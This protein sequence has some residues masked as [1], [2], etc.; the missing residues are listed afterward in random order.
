MARSR[1]RGSLGAGVS[2]GPKSA[3]G[4]TSTARQPSTNGARPEVE[5]PQTIAGWISLLRPI[6]PEHTSLLTEL[7][8]EDEGETGWELLLEESHQLLNRQNRPATAALLSAAIHRTAG[9]GRGH[10][11]RAW[12]ATCAMAFRPPPVS[13]NIDQEWL[14]QTHRAAV[15]L[16]GAFLQIARA[17]PSIGEDLRLECLLGGLEILARTHDRRFGFGH[18]LPGLISKLESEYPRIATELSSFVDG[19]APAISA[20]TV[21]DETLRKWRQ[22]LDSL[23]SELNDGIGL[24]ATRGLAL[25]SRI[26]SDNNRRVFRPIVEALE[27]ADHIDAELAA[28]INGLSPQSLLD[29]HPL[30]QAAG[31]SRKI[32]GA[33]RLDTIRHYEELAHKAQEALKLRQELEGFRKTSS[34]TD[35]GL[36]LE[37]SNFIGFWAERSVDATDWL[38]VRLLSADVLLVRSRLPIPDVSVLTRPEGAQL[39]P[40]CLFG[41]TEPRTFIAAPRLVADLGGSPS[42]IAD[43]L[44]DVSS[45]SPTVTAECLREEAGRLAHEGRFVVGRLWAAVC[46]KQAAEGYQ[47]Q[48]LL[49]DELARARKATLAE[50]ELV[51]EAVSARR[52]PGD[53]SLQE[54]LSTVQVQAQEGFLREAR[55]SFDEFCSEQFL[56][57]TELLAAPRRP[58]PAAAGELQTRDRD[59]VSVAHSEPEVAAEPRGAVIRQPAQSAN[60]QDGLLSVAEPSK[61]TSLSRGDAAQGSPDRDAL[62]REYRKAEDA[63]SRNRLREAHAS[64]Q[65]ILRADPRHLRARSQLV[66]VLDKLGRRNEA[67]DLLEDGLEVASTHV[68]FL[69][70]LVPLL[71]REGRLEEAR[72]YAQRGLDVCRNPGEEIGFLNDLVH[73]ERLT[74]NNEKAAGSLRRLVRLAPHIEH[75]QKL[76]H[77]L[78]G[79]HGSV[80]E[81]VD[82]RPIEPLPWELPSER[83]E[84]SPFLAL[85]LERPHSL[86]A[87]DFLERAG[88][89]KAVNEALLLWDKAVLTPD[90][91]RPGADAEALRTGAKLLAEVH[92]RCPEFDYLGYIEARKKQGEKL[93]S[94]RTHE[95]A[96][97]RW[98]SYYAAR[99]GDDYFMKQHTEPARAYYL[100]HFRVFGR[101][102]TF[103]AYTADKYIRTSLPEAQDAIS[104]GKEYLKRYRARERVRHAPEAVVVMFA[105]ILDQHLLGP[106]PM[107]DPRLAQFVSDFLDVCLSNEAARTALLRL[108]GDPQHQISKILWKVHC[109]GLLAVE[110]STPRDW[111]ERAM[112][113]R[114]EHHRLNE[115]DLAFVLSDLLPNRQY[116]RAIELMV[117]VRTRGCSAADQR[118]LVRVEDLL[119]AG[120]RFQRAR[121]FD[122]KRYL[123][124]DLSLRAREIQD[125]VE[126]G[127]TTLGRVHLAPL[128]FR[129]ERDVDG[130]F[131]RFKDRSPPS[132]HVRSIKSVRTDATVRAD[133]LVENQGLSPAE[134]LCLLFRGDQAGEQIGGFELDRLL[135]GASNAAVHK[136]DLRLSTPQD[137]EAMDVLV[138]GSYTDAEGRRHELPA[139]SVRLSISRHQ[140]YLWIENPYVTGGIIMDRQMFKGRDRLVSDILQEVENRRS[141][142]SVVIYGQKRCGKS[143]ILHWIAEGASDWVVPVSLPVQD[144]FADEAVLPSFLFLVAETIV[145]EAHARRNL[146]LPRIDQDELFESRVPSRV[147]RKY[148]ERVTVELGPDRRLLLLFDEFTDLI[149][150]IDRGDIERGFMRYLKSLIE[151]GLFSS[152]ICGIDTMPKALKRFSND[153][154]IADSRMISYLDDVSARELIEDPIRLSDGSSRFSAG[155][156]ERILQLTAGAPYY[157]QLLCSRLVD[158]LNREQNPDPHVTRADVD[159]TVR[160]M[161]V[162]RSKL[163]PWTVFDSLCRYKEDAQRDPYPAVLEGL[164]LYATADGMRSA[165]FVGHDSLVD[166]MRQRAPDDQIEFVLNDLLDRETLEIPKGSPVRQYRIRVGLFAE[167]ITANRPLDP[168]ALSGFAR[169]LE[170][171]AEQAESKNA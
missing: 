63:R 125:G 160:D 145:D 104:V 11:L 40:A 84:I 52:E 94:A 149:A 15:A 95:G 58:P 144:M 4:C 16:H 68:P 130:A 115:H 55:Q 110:A 43:L 35:E 45:Q 37:L 19:T 96:L 113:L 9:V 142:G 100:E 78:S 108:T 162:G 65:R 116:D 101:L 6:D 99:K 106:R 61:T 171:A 24:R 39:G 27:S 53:S 23:C 112:T 114:Q 64:F 90:T 60:H 22:R 56:D 138:S 75:Y 155:A 73:I 147:F 121:T 163:S 33:A 86:V 70:Q 14:R 151:H 48:V 38:L 157:V 117:Q 30:Q 127:P 156:I 1:A 109:R 124:S 111:V 51:R 134:N 170:T 146:E 161:I 97:R 105:A 17:T 12:E 83:L 54:R 136:A 102:F 128:V 89:E 79:P 8:T 44:R 87:G 91:A 80:P 159:E 164:A 165:E 148:L 103:S 77:Q 46:E 85:D 126:K 135:P 18:V 21:D 82:R 154:A 7:A 41:V 152:V 141:P 62:D 88:P 76:L 71:A 133:I 28:T 2:V 166:R 119:R 25:L 168:Q 81:S 123:S 42:S 122:D 98:I 32:S 131:Q 167:W 74:G 20:R 66:L 3:S 118:F 137:E 50:I 129:L 150:R 140:T 47:L 69:H 158:H 120:D 143:S 34:A 132:I 59:E 139:Q 10:V 67:I 36:A 26:Q 5:A 169:R 107:G 72:R 93:P 29:H 13:V 153:F 92:E 31:G 49:E 57:P